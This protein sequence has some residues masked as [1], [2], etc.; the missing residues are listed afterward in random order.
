MEGVKREL[1]G[2]EM[3]VCLFGGCADCF[4]ERNGVSYHKAEVYRV[5]TGDFEEF[6]CCDC[7]GKGSTEKTCPSC[8][9]FGEIT[10][11]CDTCRGTGRAVDEDIIEDGVVS[12]E[13]KLVKKERGGA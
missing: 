7:N 10:E 8:D 13:R 2:T 6:E 4:G 11:N 5:I 3:T 12:T 9:G 1:I